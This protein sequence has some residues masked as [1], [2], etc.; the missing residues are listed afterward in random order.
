[1][2]VRYAGFCYQLGKHGL[3]SWLLALT[4]SK[5]AII[6]VPQ[7]ESVG[8]ISTHLFPLFNTVPNLQ[9]KVDYG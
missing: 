7:S 6:G 9:R 1:M 3:S 4:W 8:G 2:I 5:Q